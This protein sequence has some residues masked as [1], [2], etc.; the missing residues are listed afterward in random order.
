MNTLKMDLSTETCFA[1]LCDDESIS[2]RILYSNARNLVI[3]VQTRVLL[4]I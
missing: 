1:R 2:I 3:I 4:K